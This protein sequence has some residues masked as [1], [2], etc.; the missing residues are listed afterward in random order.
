MAFSSAEQDGLDRVCLGAEHREGWMLGAVGIPR[1]RVV[2]FR[3]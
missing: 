1:W 2:S 3:A